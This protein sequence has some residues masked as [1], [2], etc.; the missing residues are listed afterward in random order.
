MAEWEEQKKNAAFCAMFLV[1]NIPMILLQGPRIT[2]ACSFL[3]EEVLE[4]T[5][6]IQGTST[7]GLWFFILCIPVTGKG[8]QNLSPQNMPLWYKDYLEQF[9]FLSF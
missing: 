2:V 3:M 4:E 1:A 6:Q 8:E 7:V 5:F 9:L